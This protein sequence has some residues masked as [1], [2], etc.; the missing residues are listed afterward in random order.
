[1]D[2]IL[3]IATEE[4]C[5]GY[6]S[7]NKNGEEENCEHVWSGWWRGRS[8]RSAGGSDVDGG[9]VKCVV[10]VDL[11]AADDDLGVDVES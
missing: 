10:D 1:M 6:D 4:Q 8:S 2:N 5:N 9:V 11:A 3:L 7:G